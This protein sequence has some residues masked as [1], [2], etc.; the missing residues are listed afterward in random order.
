MTRVLA[1]FLFSDCGSLAFTDDEVRE[2]IAANDPKAPGGPWK[3]EAL[4]WAEAI[5]FQPFT[6][7]KGESVPARIE[8]SIVQDVAYL[9]AHPLIKES[10]KIT[11]HLYDLETGK[12]TQVA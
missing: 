9:K 2:V 3:P 10:V 1:D 6:G 8:R 11:G 4:A 7:R 5:A 12:V